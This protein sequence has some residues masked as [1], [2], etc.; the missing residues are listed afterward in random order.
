VTQIG[1]DDTNTSKRSYFAVCLVHKGGHPQPRTKVRVTAR[2]HALSVS[3]SRPRV[4]NH[5]LTHSFSHSLNISRVLTHS[6]TQSFTPS[7]TDILTLMLPH[8]RS[9]SLSHSHSLPLSWFPPPI[10]AHRVAVHQRI[11]SASS[12]P[13]SHH[14][15]PH[16]WHGHFGPL[17]ST[18]TGH[19]KG[20][21]LGTPIGL[22]LL[23]M[24]FVLFASPP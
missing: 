9:L 8:S 15:P 17:A 1:A 3:W 7:S 2:F 16:V 18:Y 10:H 22:S 4:S 12:P 5:S 13:W 14:I 6:L 11:A 24:L 23:N 20:L 21:Y 19:N